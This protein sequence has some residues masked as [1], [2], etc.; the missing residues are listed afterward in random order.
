MII[1]N[2]ADYS[3]YSAWYKKMFLLAYNLAYYGT[4]CDSNNNMSLVF[5]NQSTLLRSNTLLS[6]SNGILNQINEL[7]VN[8][9]YGKFIGCFLDNLNS[10]DLPSMPYKGEKNMS[11]ELCI[12]HCQSCGYLYA[13]LQN[14]FVFY[15]I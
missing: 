7:T 12:N 5:Q 3:I 6:I 13:G 1:N 4:I 8:T 11:V 10:R 9:Y 2:Y 14:G 15:N